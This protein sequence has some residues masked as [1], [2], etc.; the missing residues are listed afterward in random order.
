MRVALAEYAKDPVA[1]LQPD[2]SKGGTDCFVD[3]KLGM[4]PGRVAFVSLAKAM[5]RAA[6]ARAMLAAGKADD[7][8]GAVS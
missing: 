8:S 7:L 1:A 2:L 6:E 4:G 5:E 3:G